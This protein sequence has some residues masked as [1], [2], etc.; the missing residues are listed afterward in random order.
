[1]NPREINQAIIDKFGSMDETGYPGAY[2]GASNGANE[3]WR[4]LSRAEQPVHVEGVGTF[5]KVEYN[6]PYDEC[7]DIQAEL[8]FSF[9]EPQGIGTYYRITGYLDS[10]EGGNWDGGIERV[11]PVPVQTIKWESA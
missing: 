5:V 11:K 7:G 3:F 9:A 1:M 10:W 8:I 6:A 4:D 2:W